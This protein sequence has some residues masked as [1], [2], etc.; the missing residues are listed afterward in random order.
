MVAADD[1]FTRG[2]ARFPADP[3]I[4]AWAGYA[5]QAGRAALDDPDLAHWHQC[6]GTWF[7]G[8]DTLPNDPAG[9]VGGSGPLAGPAVDFITD[10][11]GPLPP[12]HR[13]QLSVIFPGYPRPRSGE[14]VAAFRYRQRRDAAHVDGVLAVG[15]ER[16][17]RVQEPHAF[18]LGLPL[19]EASA[20]AAPLVVW[21]GSHEI[22]RRA[23]AAALRAHPLAEWANVDVTEAY[24]AARREVFARCRRV[25]L[26]AAPGEACL[27]HRLALHGVA[28]WAD[29]ATAGPEGRMIAYFRPEMPGGSPA[30]LSA[31]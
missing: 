20:D 8:V 5:R 30:W 13:A 29:T 22:M 7:V 27:L 2:W 12:L 25:P 23:F 4:R 11:I 15:P 28:L 17:R 3:V 16:R 10:H 26:P 18:I 9:A 14:S 24:V 1:F 31:P 6:E 21:E 19:S